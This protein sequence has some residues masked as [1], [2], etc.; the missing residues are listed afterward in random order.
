MPFASKKQRSY[1]YANHPEVA[2][3]F[4]SKTPKGARLPA[5]VRQKQKKR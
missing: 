4:Q 2:R 5:R 3:E 1:L